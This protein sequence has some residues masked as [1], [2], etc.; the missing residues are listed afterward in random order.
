M[1]SISKKAKRSIIITSIA[2]VSIGIV[3][4][5]MVNA[6]SKVKTDNGKTVTNSGATITLS[7]DVSPNSIDSENGVVSGSGKAFNPETESSR[8]EPLTTCSKSTSTP[9]KPVVEGDSKNG[10][11]PTNSA[12]TDKSKKPT[13]KTA[14]KASTNSS[15]TTKKSSS[16]SS[17][18]TKKSTSSSTGSNNDPIFGNGANVTKGGANEATSMSGDHDSD[19]NEQVGIMD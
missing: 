14:P 12:L 7:S 17:T 18:S 16:K 19:D 5:V 11:Q 1:K 8:S 13:Y 15:T 4:A 10:S 3:S 9:S 6:N 2:V